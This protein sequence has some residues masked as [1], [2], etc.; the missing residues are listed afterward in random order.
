[1]S[2]MPFTHSLNRDLLYIVFRHHDGIHTSYHSESELSSFSKIIG[3]P[4]SMEMSIKSSLDIVTNA[5]S[6]CDMYDALL[7]TKRD[8]RKNPYEIIFVLFLLFH[9][10]SDK[11]FFEPLLR[12]FI[13]FLCSGKHVSP[14]HALS[15]FK[16]G[17]KL[18]EAIRSI[19]DAFTIKK[20]HEHD[21]DNFIRDN[22]VRFHDFISSGEN[23][24]LTELTR[25]WYIYSEEKRSQ[26]MVHFVN[27]LNK[28]GLFTATTRE[29]EESGGKV[30]LM[31]LDFYYSYSSSSKQ[32]KFI[33]YLKEAVL[34]SV[35]DDEVKDRII[36]LANSKQYESR[37][38]FE[39][40][41][42]EECFNRRN[43]FEAFVSYDE[44]TLINE[45]NDFIRRS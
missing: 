26:R 39:K 41:L 42:T 7:D 28:A 18:F 22:K 12:E 3:Y 34:I 35:F 19:H 21:F 24:L 14:D 2:E 1:M 37:K 31:L 30:F 32:K 44:N 17:E 16:D 20:E 10:M 25:S 5:L 8:Y 6:L 9:E 33:E 36:R 11:K 29:A 4:I 40:L 23:G 13:L 43:L 15:V 27:E 38:D 45:L